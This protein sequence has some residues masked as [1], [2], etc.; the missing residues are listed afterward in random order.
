MTINEFRMLKFALSRDF[1]SFT[2]RG[3]RELNQGGSFI[4]NWHLDAVAWHLKKVMAGETKRLII[5]LPPRS[6]KS[7]MVSVLFPASWLGHDPRKKIFG[8]SYGGDLAAKHA[9]DSQSIMQTDW[10]RLTFPRTRIT[11]IADSSIYTDQRGFRKATS[12]NAT[13]T[14]LGGDC[15]IIDDPL[16]PVDAQ[17]EPLR[18]AVNDWISHT[19][20]SRLDDKAKG[21]IIVVMQRVHQH[22]LTGYLTENFP[23]TWTLLSL[24]A[25]AREEETVEIGPKRFHSR[26]IGEALHPDREPIEVLE[27][28][29]RELGSD[30]F[31]GQYQ[32][33]PVPPGGA[34]VKR[35]WLQYYDVL[36]ERTYP[37][38]VIQSWDTAVK[39]GAQNDFSV[40]TTWLM[41]GNKFYL[42][43][44]VRERFEYPRLKQTALLLADKFKP[45]VILIEDASTGSPLAQELRQAGTFAVR[46]V[47]VE[48]DKV[49]RLYVQ[50]A[51]FEA[52][53]VFFPR[54]ASYLATLEAELLS[55]PQSKHDDQVDSIT[56]ALGSQA[57]KYRYDTSLSWVG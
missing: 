34:M 49:A 50:Q 24:P 22:D 57:S 20:I 3:V 55:F 35:D 52:G 19:L 54:R 43:D 15:F 4:H 16:K 42:M 8:I 1:M 29:R 17:S 21:A 28:V 39:N 2:D 56:Q 23:G 53:Q 36:P 51:K 47:P 45:N 6:L 18:N 32:Q 13:L 30:I 25:I 7:L 38:R 26:Q 41:V 40:C 9:R 44:L 27:N 46:L 10:Y 5:N 37:A 31:E 14:G 12:I 11:R 48:H 33:S